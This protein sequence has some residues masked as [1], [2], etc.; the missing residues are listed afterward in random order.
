MRRKRDHSASAAGRKQIRILKCATNPTGQNS[1]TQK[2]KN[3]K[4]QK[5]KNSKT[6]KLKNSKT[7]KLRNSGTQELRNSGTQELKDLG[8]SAFVSSKTPYTIVR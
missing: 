4:T 3:S 2:L 6:Q 8:S 1:R 5:L 7:Q